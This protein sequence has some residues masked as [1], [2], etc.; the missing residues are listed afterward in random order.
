[1]RVEQRKP[2]CEDAPGRTI[3][4]GVA[5]ALLPLF[6]LFSLVAVASAQDISGGGGTASAGTI[7]GGTCAPQAVTVISSTG[8]PTCASFAD[9]VGIASSTA[10][11]AVTF[12][13]TGGK[14][15][16][17]SGLTITPT[18]GGS[19]ITFGAAA[20]AAFTA[21][22]T[23]T[24]TNTLTYGG[25]DGSTIAFGTGGSVAYQGG[26][27]TGNQVTNLHVAGTSGGIPY[28]SGATAISSSAALTA[29]RIV[30]GGGAGVAPTIVGSLG[31]ATTVLHGGA[32][33]PTFGA[34]DVTT[35]IVGITPSA[36]GG[37]ENQFFKISGPATT[38]RTFT[39][40]N[41]NAT[42]LTDNAAV[43]VPQGGTGQQTLTSHGMVYGLGTSGV[44]VTAECTDGQVF[45]GHTG[46]APGCAAG[47]TGSVTSIT[48]TVPAF[49]TASNCTITTSGTCALTTTSQAANLILAAPVGSSGAMVPRLLDPSDFPA[50]ITETSQ[51]AGVSIG[52]YGAT[53]DVHCASPCTLVLPAVAA[54]TGST[55]AFCIRN[56]SA[57]TTLDGNAAETIDGLLTRVMLPGECANL[58]VRNSEW[59]KMSGKSIVATVTASRTAG[60][61]A[62]TAGMDNVVLMDTLESGQASMWDAGNGRVK[63]LR[64]GLYKVTMNLSFNA[65]PAADL[66]GMWAAVN[67]GSS[68][69]TSTTTA[70]S[71]GVFSANYASNDLTLALA[72]YLVVTVYDN[73]GSNLLG[74]GGAAARITLTEVAPW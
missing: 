30:L 10:N 32:G 63:T 60:D 7:T 67:G 52:T 57:I 33:A 36:N 74:S 21:A 18:S 40:A 29:N 13:D 12:G 4:R 61:A 31:S 20:V 3:S 54:H 49:L 42:I 66:I 59:T 28:F 53:Y 72:D 8:V 25:T 35:D 22:K 71:S 26:D 69:T 37:V 48:V 55:I 19:T 47:G 9:F 15:A 17:S 1:M 56:G 5:T 38:K 51:T 27:I 65:V 46:A 11:I 44:G 68:T 50:A 45:V 14:L 58:I 43:T 62:L 2:A 16:K 34:V 64:P 73:N 41:A 70:G 39:I 6:V 23:N 24:F